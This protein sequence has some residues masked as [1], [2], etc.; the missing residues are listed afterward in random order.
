MAS[1]VFENLDIDFEKYDLLSKIE[2]AVLEKKT[3]RTIE[4]R[5]KKGYYETIEVAGETKVLFPKRFENKPDVSKNEGEPFETNFEVSK[6]SPE[7]F[8]AFFEKQNRLLEKVL[9]LTDT[10]TKRDEIISGL[11]NQLTSAHAIIKVDKESGKAER[12]I[13]E[14]QRRLEALETENSQLKRR[15]WWKFW[16]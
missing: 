7:A 15:K 8:E 4:N 10:V 6:I 16:G 1:K 14:L 5:I 11:N 2:V 3:E 12:V 9:E 13:E